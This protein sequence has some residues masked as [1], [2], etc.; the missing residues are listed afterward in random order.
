MSREQ[1][2]SIDVNSATTLE[3]YRA[4]RRDGSGN[5]VYATAGEVAIGILQNSPTVGKSGRV[6]IDGISSVQLSGTT[7]AGDFL[8]PDALGKLRVAQNGDDI[9]CQ[10]REA[11]VANAVIQADVNVAG[12]Y[13]NVAGGSVT[14]SGVATELAVWSGLSSLTSIPNG[15]GAL[16]NDG[17][18]NYT[19]ESAGTPTGTYT[20]P[21]T[22]AVGDVVASTG[23][24]AADKAD[25]DNPAA[26][27]A[28][29]IVVSKPT[30]TSAVVQYVG[31]VGGL[32]GL[33]AGSAYFL[34]VTA[35]AMTTTA[36]ASPA[37]F[38]KIGFAKT[39]TVF[40]AQFT[41]DFIVQT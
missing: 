24:G 31:E 20:V 19:W 3:A 6:L 29:G 38:Q 10:A 4:V 9:V 16:T 27:P 2:T 5:L 25:A 41:P 30:A 39:A 1:A 34:D 33:S 12:T 35:G 11:G 32:S 13:G 36:P 40:V 22:V 37:I 26:R 8:S 17:S 15:T 18:G 21:G 28:I 7:K 14:G 23:S